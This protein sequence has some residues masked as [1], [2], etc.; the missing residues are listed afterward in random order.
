MK[1]S[2]LNEIVGSGGIAPFMNT[3]F[4]QPNDEI[5]KKKTTKKSKNKK[6]KRD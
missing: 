1:L 5:P 6:L 4:F 2:L 3:N